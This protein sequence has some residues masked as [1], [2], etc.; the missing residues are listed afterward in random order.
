MPSSIVPYIVMPLE[1]ALG[2]AEPPCAQAAHSSTVAAMASRSFMAVLF[3]K[4]RF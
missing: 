2:G 3:S 1:S 4:D